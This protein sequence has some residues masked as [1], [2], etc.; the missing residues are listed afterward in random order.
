MRLE[1]QVHA[2]AGLLGNPSDGYFGKTLS[3]LVGNFKARVTLE[4]SAYLSLQP[5]P[6]FDPLE[7]QNITELGVIYGK[8]GYYGG[9]RLLQAACKKFYDECTKRGVHLHGPNFTMSYDT[10]IPR[11]VGMSGS[12]AIVIATLRALLCWYDVMDRFKQAEFPTIA[13][14]TEQEELGITAGMQDRVIQTYGGL[15]YMDFDRDVMSARGYGLY[16]RLDASLLP[17]MYLA[18]V[19]NPSDSGKIHSD[20]RR[21][22]NE[23][24]PEVVQAMHTFAGFADSGRAALERGDVGTFSRLFDEAFALRRKIFG[25]LVLGPDNLRMTE[26]A[27]AHGLPATTC[28]SGGAIVG[29]MGDEPQNAAFADALAAEGYHFMRLVVGPAY[30][31]AVEHCR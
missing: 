2:R 29:V 14:E 23:S 18:Y 12:S 17:P 16:E 10:D 27:R 1:V 5:H 21:R 8:Q 26:I 11:Q 22:W 15:M 13:L 20:V 30:P 3:C 28:G 4:E 9:L 6:Q 19:L 31:W 7:F 24:E 25:D